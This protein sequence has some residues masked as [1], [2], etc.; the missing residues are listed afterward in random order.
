MKPTTPP[1]F[2]RNI[3]EELKGM[4]LLDVLQGK[5]LRH[6]MHPFLAHVPVG[7]WPTALVLDVIAIIKGGNHPDLTLTA[8][9]CIL[10]GL[11]VALLAVP[12]GIADWWSIKRQ[13]PAWSLGLIHAL[14]NVV[15]FA[16]FLADFIIRCR[17]GPAEPDVTAIQL[18]LS[19]V[20]TGIL[21]VSVYLGG[22]LVY[23]HGISVARTSKKHW[24]ELAEAGGAVV[25]Q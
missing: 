2:L 24:R 16:L 21:F 22:R 11:A 14:L 1:E 6:P 13:R 25:P 23:E 8:W 4:T 15:V 17:R 7:L 18:I 20:G 9:W 3:T 5:P 19:A 12:T 10:A